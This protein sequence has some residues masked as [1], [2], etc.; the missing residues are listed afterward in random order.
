MA[1][2][3]C[4]AVKASHVP[5]HP[6]CCKASCWN[7]ATVQGAPPDL[8]HDCLIPAQVKTGSNHDSSPAAGLQAGHECPHN[9]HIIYFCFIMNRV[10]FSAE[11]I[12][13]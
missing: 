3:E 11:V 5:F 8:S 9:V 2:E 1:V 12:P 13:K 6:T 4:G 10:G 7:G